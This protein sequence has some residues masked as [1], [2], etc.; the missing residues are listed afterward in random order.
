MT[1]ALPKSETHLGT[2]IVGFLAAIAAIYLLRDSELTSFDMAL[3]VL[4][5]SVTPILL[6]EFFVFKRHREARAALTAKRSVSWKRVALKCLGL[7][8]IIL[9]FGTL[10]VL[11]PEYDKPFYHAV[12]TFYLALVSTMMIG[13]PFYFAW[14][15]ARQDS[16]EDGYYYLGRMMLCRWSGNDKTAMIRLLRNWLVKAFFLPLMLVYCID[17]IHDIQSTIFT[18][19]ITLLAIFFAAQAIIMF[20]DLLYATLGYIFTLRI[21]NA[22][23]RSSEP[24]FLG[25]FVALACYAP[26]WS[27]LLYP[28]FFTYDDGRNWHHILPE[29][30]LQY[31]W[32]G[33]ILSALAIYTL[34]TICLGIRFSNLTYRGLV[35]NG[36]Y[37]FS[38]HPAYVAKNLS[39]WMVSLPFIS[40]AGTLAALSH[41]AALIGINV[42]Y[43]I[44]A[45]TEERHLSN[46]PE[47][48]EYALAMNERSIFAPLAKRLPFLIYQKNPSKI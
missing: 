15:D 43:F 13:A 34:A 25:W 46:Y 19:P 37:R 42:L 41:T 12:W 23:I 5:A 11:I 22:H 18:K 21:F 36:P 32:G 3:A 4:A 6:I 16:A 20:G 29:G 48:V 2:N 17:S 27:T 39:W 44:R 40:D 7:T 28:R 1:P 24:T 14:C 8:S 47:Y 45:R 26:F 38:K 33:C 9:L 31:V 35:T 30:W 10:Y